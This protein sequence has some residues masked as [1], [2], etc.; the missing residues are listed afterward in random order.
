MSFSLQTA[1]IESPAAARPRLLLVEDDSTVRILLED[2]LEKLGWQVESAENGAE[3]FTML[4]ETPSRADVVLTDRMMPVMDGLAM[5]RRMKRDRELAHIPVVMLTGV[6]GADD[7]DAGLSAGVF[8]YLE[9]S[10]PPKVL[11]SVLSAA[12]QDVRRQRALSA[13]LGQHRAGFQN[14]QLA[15]FQLSKPSEVE[16]VVSLMASLHDRPELIIQGIYELV[17]NA[18]EHGVL[19][20]GFQAKSQLV[21]SGGWKRALTERAADPAYAAGVAEASILRREGGLYVV[22]K[23]NGPGFEWRSFAD[24][25]P[26]RAAASCGRGL[27]RAAATT[28]QQLR[29]N[30]TGNQVVG[31]I[32]AARRVQW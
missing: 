9:K 4:R 3:A 15:R 10:S 32:P 18:I 28:F 14:L 20:F 6:A 21:A 22:V 26:V 25:D 31:F 23:D 13:E 16:P 12:L 27:A 5:T 29:F 11:A 19:R 1:T 24:S 30:T 17:Q 8:Y 2:R 7:V